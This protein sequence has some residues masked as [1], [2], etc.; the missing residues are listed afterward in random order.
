VALGGKSQ[1]ATT[2]KLLWMKDGAPGTW[3]AC[4]AESDGAYDGAVL[5]RYLLLTPSVLVDVFEVEAGEKT[6]IDWFAHALS[7]TLTLHGDPLAT[8]PASPGDANGYQHLTDGAK[9]DVSGNTTWIFTAADK[10]LLTLHLLG[11]EPETIF[12]AR[13]I[14]YHTSQL[15]PTLIRRREAQQTRFVTV[16]DLSGKGTFVR[17]VRVGKGEAIELVTESG[18]RSIEFS[19][20]GV[21]MD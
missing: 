7:D 5:R 8:T 12:T 20:V 19:A 13:G 16:Y 9:L 15:V 17:S 2:G 10:R 18:V 11:G 6:Q 3:T 1:A 14:G 4:A 21:K